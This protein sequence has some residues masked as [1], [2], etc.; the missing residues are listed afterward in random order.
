MLGPACLGAYVND[1]N[2]A[3]NALL[4]R[5]VAVHLLEQRLKEAGK[6]DIRIIVVT[7]L[8]VTGIAAPG[9][10]LT[11]VTIRTATSGS[12]WTTLTSGRYAS[13]IVNAGTRFCS[14]SLG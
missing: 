12:S 4:R 8:L 9:D 2:K 7:C 10:I 11:T 1:L 6:R 14:Q 13:D 5:K 3:V